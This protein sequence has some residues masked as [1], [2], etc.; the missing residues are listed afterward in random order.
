MRKLKQRQGT[1]KDKNKKNK[2]E[3]SEW[4]TLEKKKK[5]DEVSN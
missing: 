4:V 3:T 1:N 2:R 5:K